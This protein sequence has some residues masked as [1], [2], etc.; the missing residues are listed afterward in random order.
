MTNS[1][2][3]LE[4]FRLVALPIAVPFSFEVRIGDMVYVSDQIGHRP[5]EMQ[6]VDGWLEPEAR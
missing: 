5:G 4:I 2:R 1:I 3:D 6:L